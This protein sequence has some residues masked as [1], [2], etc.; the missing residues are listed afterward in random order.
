MGGYLIESTGA[1]C[2]VD[3]RDD[4]EKFFAEHNVPASSVSMTRAI[5]RINGCV[6]LRRLQE[7]NLQKWLVT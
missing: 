7:P 1:F 6:E 2:T 5:D 4:V 3:A